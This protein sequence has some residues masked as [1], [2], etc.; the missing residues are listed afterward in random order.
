MVTA[1][2]FWALIKFMAAY[3]LAFVIAHLLARD[4]LM[5]SY[6]RLRFVLSK[7]FSCD[8]PFSSLAICFLSAQVL[9]L[10]WFS[11]IRTSSRDLVEGFGELVGNSDSTWTLFWFVARFLSLQGFN[12][13]VDFLPF[14]VFVTYTLL[15][16]LSSSVTYIRLGRI[17]LLGHFVTYTL[18]GILSSLVTYICLGG[19]LLL[20]HS[21]FL[22]LT[23]F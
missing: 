18:L 4:M 21:L 23:P 1:R 14:L 11:A 3:L 15:G 8:F 5:V 2:C 10:S 7:N 19:I 17:L 16:I 9:L 12:Y 6:I 22:W 20:G 13:L